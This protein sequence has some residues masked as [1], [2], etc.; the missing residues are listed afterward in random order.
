[1][2]DYN[3]ALG[4][5]LKQNGSLETETIDILQANNR[6]LAQEI[7]SPISLP[8]YHNSA[9]DGYALRSHET[10]GASSDHPIWL[11]P[12]QCIA[13]GDKPDSETKNIKSHTMEIMTGAPVPDL[14][15]CV[16]PVENV[17]LSEDKS[18]NEIGI[19]NPISN[20]S[21]IRYKGEDI[22][23]GDILLSKGEQ[24]N[25]S[26]MMTL[27]G[28]GIKKIEVFKKPNLLVLATGKELAVDQ[29]LDTKFLIN[30]CNSPF[31]YTSLSNQYSCDVRVDHILSDT[32]E[33]FIKFMNDE[34]SNEQCPDIIISTGAVSA[35]KFDFIP[36]SLALM[37]A[38][39]IFHKVAIRPGKPILFAVLPNGTFYFGLPG[40]PSAVASGLRFFVY[41]LLRKL[42]HLPSEKPIYAELDQDLSLQKPLCF[43]QKSFHYIDE[44]GISRV[45]ILT[46]QAS[47]MIKPM[48]QANAW[49]MLEFAPL[50]IQ[51]NTLVAV[52]KF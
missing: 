21:N 3:E 14:F 22:T 18:S 27:T 19:I 17:L 16:I 10:Q 11:Q 25:S 40:N 30:D 35:G 28:V 33:E 34:L 48:L 43:F 26:R 38:N 4:L 46:G 1:M 50:S 29:P 41:P 20:G 47:F 31:L 32:D 45:K 5:I 24:I 42:N 9:M 23:Q 39:I 37:G 51:K 12:T 49:V 15:D 2:I 52:Y 7:K 44:N 6:T 36:R 8:S 13:A